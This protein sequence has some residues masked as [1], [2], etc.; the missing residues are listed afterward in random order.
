MKYLKYFLILLFI[1]F[2]VLAEECDISKITIKS[3]SFNS[4]SKNVEE[5]GEPVYRNRNVSLNVKMHDVGDYIVYDLVIKNDN[6]EDYM[7]NED[8]FT[9]DSKFIKYELILDGDNV[10][11]ANNNKEMKLKVSYN[12]SVDAN[13]F[14]SGKYYDNNNLTFNMANNEKKQKIDIISSDKSLNVENPKTNQQDI[15]MFIMLLVIMIVIQIVLRKKKITK[16]ISIIIPLLVFNIV[17]AVCNCEIKMETNIEIDKVISNPCFYTGDLVQGAEYVKG[18][19]TY[20][21]MQEMNNTEW[22]NISTDGWGVKLTDP[23]STKD[24]TTKLCTTIND[25]PIVSMQ[26]MFNN[27][28]T[29]RIDLSSFD[30]SNVTNM[31]GMFYGVA[32]VEQYDLS[33]FNTQNVTNM[34]SMFFNNSKLKSVYLGGF[35]TEN[36]TNFS[37]MFINDVLLEEINL[38]N[39][40]LMKTGGSGAL[41]GLLSST[42]SLKKISMKNWV[43]PENFSH[44]ISR[45]F[46]GSSSPIEIVDVTGWDLTNTKD[47][48]GFFADSRHL[49]KI[50]GLDTW[51]TSNITAMTTLFYSCKN[52]EKLDLSSFDMKNVVDAQAMLI[53]VDSLKEIITPKD[54]PSNESVIVDLP[55]AFKDDE[56]NS[57]VILNNSAKKK[58]KLTL[59]LRSIFDIGNIVNNKFKILSNGQVTKIIRTNTT[60]DITNMGENNIVSPAKYKIPIYAW[61][62]NGTIYYYSENE[63]IYMN[64][65]SS[66]MFCSLDQLTTV[67]FASIDTSLVKNMAYLFNYTGQY[68]NSFS[69]DVSNFDVSNVV[70]MTYLFRSA[71]RNAQTINIAGLSNWDVS[72]VEKSN[73][74]FASFAT[75]GKDVKLTIHNWKF[76]EKANLEYMFAFFAESANSV[77]LDLTGWDLSKIKSTSYMFHDFADG[78]RDVKLK[79]KDWDTSGVENMS[80]MF[81]HAFYYSEYIDMDFSTWD[82]SNVKNMECMFQDFGNTAKYSMKLNF[83]GW[84]TSSVTNMSNMFNLAGSYVG[85]NNYSGSEVIYTGLEDWDVSNVESMR[86]M[87]DSTGKYAKTFILGNLSNW[88]FKEGVDMSYWL[89][90]SSY[91]ASNVNDIGTLN[92]KSSKITYLFAATSNVKVTINLLRPVTDYSSAFSYAATIPGSQI[93]VNYVPEVTNIDNIISTKSSDSNVIKGSVIN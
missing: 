17:Y 45:T 28:Q 78:S 7:I 44:G 49:K 60:P 72:N 90:Q 58:T 85:E 23:T 19:Y 41:G 27:S 14:R 26:F 32:N 79:V 34:S 73:E 74:M 30:T 88:N 93:T 11:K 56:D 53:S 25:K 20:R 92:I 18:Q 24:V 39:W 61:F 57:Y 67:D 5:L 75:N 62:D 33:S 64:P 6:K 15:Y 55:F 21:Y 47:I 36:V 91:K 48:S 12:S 66:Y 31:I 16:Y 63:K 42:S 69:I 84:D 65:D 4:K 2:V 8:S 46:S 35:N 40:N 82:T 22:V 87:F 50:K 68:A 13:L 3:I 43:V 29:K 76:N 77:D 10:I 51:D 70:D 59:D 1:P 52:L 81:N 89:Y 38:D 83:T 80:L 71:A 86:Q 9:T 54:Y 37:G